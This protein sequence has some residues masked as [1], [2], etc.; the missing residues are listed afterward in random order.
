MNT[1]LRDLIALPAF[2]LVSRAPLVA[3]G[4]VGIGAL[5]LLN[6]PGTSLVG[7]LPVLAIALLG[8]LAVHLVTTA[9]VLRTAAGERRTLEDACWEAADR[10]ADWAGWEFAESPDNGPTQ[11]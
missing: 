11:D 2:Y 7:S 3:A 6:T 10:V 4:V 1:P 5:L 9:P 8:V